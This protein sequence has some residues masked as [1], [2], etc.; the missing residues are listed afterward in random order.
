M[1]H[2]IIERRVTVLGIPIKREIVSPGHQEL[3][4]PESVSEKLLD[5]GKAPIPHKV[6]VQTDDKVTEVS[7]AYGITGKGIAWNASRTLE[8]EDMNQR[9]RKV[10]SRLTWWGSRVS[11]RWKPSQ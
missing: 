1:L 10:H 5:K 8:G 4:S 11:Y 7:G 9:Y 2:M 6:L 3:L